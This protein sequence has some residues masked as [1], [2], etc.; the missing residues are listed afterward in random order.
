MT[1]EDFDKLFE[2][3]NFKEKIWVLV[4]LYLYIEKVGA[5]K[6][7]NLLKEKFKEE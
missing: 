6:V 7:F 5:E 1:Q 2:D 4:M 3:E